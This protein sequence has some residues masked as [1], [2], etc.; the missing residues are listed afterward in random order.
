[1]KFLFSLISLVCAAA[2]MAQCCG[3]S[4][5]DNPQAREAEFMA[6]ANRMALKAQGKEACCQTD[7]TKSVEKGAKGCCNAKAEPAKFKVFVAGEGYK[8]FGCEGSAKKGRQELV[9]KGEKVG[10][11]QKVRTKVSL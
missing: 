9:A 7:A 6:E 11:V 4:K 10:R 1:M 5:A 2:A 8:Y 3:G